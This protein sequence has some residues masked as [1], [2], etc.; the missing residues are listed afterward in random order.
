MLGLVESPSRSQSPVAKADVDNK[1]SDYT[2]LFPLLPLPLGKEGKKIHVHVDIRT[3]H[4]EREQERAA[5]Q[6]KG[7]A[8]PKK[9]IQRYD[10]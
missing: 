4:S 7:K 8:A 5:R 3:L 1:V 6:E 10:K 9:Y 2:T